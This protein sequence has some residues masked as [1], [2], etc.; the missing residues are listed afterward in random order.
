M[1][2]YLHIFSYSGVL[3]LEL[4]II[5]GFLFVFTE[6]CIVVTGSEDTSVQI[7]AI[8]CILAIH[9]LHGLS[10]SVKTFCLPNLSF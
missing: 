1:M 2:L 9:W 6:G 8:R 3:N 4:I 5:Q 10:I 7:S